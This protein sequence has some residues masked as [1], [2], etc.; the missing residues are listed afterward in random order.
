MFLFWGADMSVVDFALKE[1][2]ALMRQRNDLIPA[3]AAAKARV[4][5]DP[6]DGRELEALIEQFRATDDVMRESFCVLETEIAA[7]R[8][9]DAPLPGDNEA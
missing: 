2:Q 5:A 6:S 4:D 7:Q 9:A 3:L 1:F 8:L